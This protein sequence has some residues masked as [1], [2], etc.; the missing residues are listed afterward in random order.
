MVQNSKILFNDRFEELRKFGFS[1][2]FTCLKNCQN[3]LKCK[4]KFWSLLSNFV[5][6]LTYGLYLE[7]AH[8]SQKN[9]DLATPHGFKF[10]ARNCKRLIKEP[11]NRFQGIDSASL[12]SLSGRYVKQG[13][14]TGPPILESIP[15]LFKRF[16][17]KFGLSIRQ[18]AVS[19]KPHGF[20][21][22]V[23]FRVKAA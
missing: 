11:M 23:F 4:K 10:R 19:S 6:F 8:I 17:Y 9:Q 21:P 5:V 18:H 13:C 7:Y 12:C 2:N 20:T 15:G 16:I 3:C 1:L 14:C 22:V